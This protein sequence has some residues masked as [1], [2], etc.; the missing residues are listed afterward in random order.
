MRHIFLKIR[1]WYLIA[2]EVRTNYET[3]VIKGGIELKKF[4]QI[5][6]NLRQGN[7][8]LLYFQIIE[9]FFC[10]VGNPS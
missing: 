8:N 4:F 9:R 7:S 10:K 3:L 2:T 5:H 1:Y 6:F